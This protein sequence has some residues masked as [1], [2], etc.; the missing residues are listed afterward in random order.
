MKKWICLFSLL[1][2]AC[3]ARNAETAAIVEK[4]KADA[5][6]YAHLA[7][8]LVD[9]YTK[10]SEVVDYSIQIDENAATAEVEGVHV[11]M[12]IDPEKVKKQHQ[13]YQSKAEAA[14]SVLSSK[15][16]RKVR[17]AIAKEMDL[18]KIVPAYTQ[19][20]QLSIIRAFPELDPKN[21][22]IVVTTK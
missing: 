10:M 14:I 19:M 4:A 20:V 8:R 18:E 7:A 16:K 3:F 1:T 9:K 12:R 6:V 15:A 13:L 2:T 17:G 5:L 21:I 22:E 11:A